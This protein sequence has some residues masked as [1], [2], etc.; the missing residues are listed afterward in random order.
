MNHN[1]KL[2]VVKLSDKAIIPT[3]GSN[4][5][6]GYDVYS[7]HDYEL[8]ARGKVLVK[9]DI[10]IEVPTG[11]YGRIAPRSGLAWNNHIDFD[12]GV[13][14]SDYRGN[15]GVVMFNHSETPFLIKTGDRVAQLICEK[16]L[17][18]DVLLLDSLDKTMCGDGGFGST[19]VV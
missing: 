16:I 12:A 17:Y 2:K 7:V 18:A 15:I 13:I 14:D 19:G 9:T 11:T 5:A 1:S 4:Y 6:A 8:D 3:K 10:Q